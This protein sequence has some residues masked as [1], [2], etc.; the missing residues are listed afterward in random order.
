MILNVMIIHDDIWVS[1]IEGCVLSSTFIAI[2]S[3][4]IRAALNAVKCGSGKSTGMFTSSM[5]ATESY[6]AAVE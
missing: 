6:T 4:S 5:N 1:F 2:I 3:W